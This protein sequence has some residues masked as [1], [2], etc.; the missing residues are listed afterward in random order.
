MEARPCSVEGCSSHRLHQRY[1][2]WHC[3]RAG[4]A[5]RRH[6]TEWL[7]RCG[8]DRTHPFQA[9]TE[10]GVRVVHD[11]ANLSRGEAVRG[12]IEHAVA[13]MG[14]IDILVITQASST[15]PRSRS[16]C[17]EV[18]CDPGV[19]SLG[20]VP[21][22]GGGLAPYEAAGRRSH[23]QHRIRARPGGLGEQVGLCGGQARRGGVT[24]VTAL[25]N[26]GSGITANAICPGWVRTAL[27]EQQITA[28]AER[29][30]TD[31]ETAARALLAEKQPSLQ[32]V[33]P[34]QLGEWWCSWPR[35]L[36]RR[37]PAW[38]CRWMGAGRRASWLAVLYAAAWA[39]PPAWREW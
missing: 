4:P 26:A 1:R 30:G 39:M 7:R 27:V 28:L 34:E 37:L 31:Q 11:A 21:C 2:S 3:H 8:G 36:R 16:S 6:R 20:R 35:T 38:R 22:H 19:E 5:R 29:Q 10:F 14:R 15:P 25:E 13:T 32:F 33:T 23:H 24:K 18:G 12:M 17:R 9:G